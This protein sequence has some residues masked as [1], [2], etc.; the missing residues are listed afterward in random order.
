MEKELEMMPLVYDDGG[1]SKYFKG[2]TGDCVCRAIAIASGMDYKEVYRG[3]FSAM[4]RAPRKGLKTS[5]KAF[6]DY[7]HGLGFVW[8]SLCSVGSTSSAHLI[9]GELPNG[10][11]CCSAHHHYVAVIDGVV[12]D[13]W[14]SRYNSWCEPRRIYGYWK[15]NK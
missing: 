11:L 10:R 3:L 5:K 2:R 8:V 1:R 4:G 14:D 9:K 12:H 6:K 7:M 15:F 13:T